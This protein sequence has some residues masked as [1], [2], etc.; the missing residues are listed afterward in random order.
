MA[1][2]VAMRIAYVQQLVECE[3]ARRCRARQKRRAGLVSG[4]GYDVGAPRAQGGNW[5]SKVTGRCF[6]VL[7]QSNE[8][9]F[10]PN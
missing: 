2:A 3:R 5:V 9:A 6:S 7:K 4:G 1:T 8:A 10:G